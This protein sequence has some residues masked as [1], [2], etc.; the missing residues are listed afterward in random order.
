MTTVNSKR[1]SQTTIFTLAALHC[2]PTKLRH[3][4]TG[5]IALTLLH[6]EPIK[7][8]ILLMPSPPLSISRVNRIGLRFSCSHEQ[9]SLL[10][11]NDTSQE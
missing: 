11:E 8:S 2:A 7:R 1:E 6:N 5:I 10:P 3:P 9:E 4:T